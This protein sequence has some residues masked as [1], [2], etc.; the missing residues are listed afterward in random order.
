MSFGSVHHLGHIGIRLRT[1]LLPDAHRLL[2]SQRELFRAISTAAI[3]RDEA[4]LTEVLSRAA[5]AASA[6]LATVGRSQLI[7]APPAN[8]NLAAATWAHLVNSARQAVAVARESIPVVGGVAAAVA[9]A[10]IGT[11]IVS[12]WLPR[13]M[14]AAGIESS[15]RA[16]RRRRRAAAE[17]EIN[18]GAAPANASAAPDVGAVPSTEQVQDLMAEVTALKAELARYQ[19]VNLEISSAVPTR[20]H[21]VDYGSAA[22]HIKHL[23]AVNKALTHQVSTLEAEL[24]SRRKNEEGL[25]GEVEKLKGQVDELQEERERSER[26]MLALEGSLDSLRM[27]FSSIAAV[28]NGTSGTR[29]GLS[30]PV[31]PRSPIQAAAAV[32][33]LSSSRHPEL[34]PILPMIDVAPAGAADRRPSVIS[35]GSMLSPAEPQPRGTK[36]D[37]SATVGDLHT[38]E[39]SSSFSDVAKAALAGVDSVRET[40]EGLAALLVS[41]ENEEAGSSSSVTSSA[42]MLTMSATEKLHD[43][44]LGGALQTEEDNRSEA[45]MPQAVEEGLEEEEWDAVEDVHEAAAA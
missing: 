19:H 12:V 23:E 14:A 9:I 16:A 30:S 7:L 42:E 17:A 45:S 36:E 6:S 2:L 27:L 28:S 22:A 18:E 20:E 11:E 10:V 40:E 25:K 34:D 13:W 21:E 31:A 4:A 38:V 37:A 43:D 41:A 44:I 29:T 1:D 33:L 35:L 32:S 5:S 15:S 3:G 26:R 39:L 24:A 8:P